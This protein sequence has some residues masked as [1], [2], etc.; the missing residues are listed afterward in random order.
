MEKLKLQK[1]GEDHIDKITLDND[2]NEYL[3][4]V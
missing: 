2:E 1:M 4:R 3:A